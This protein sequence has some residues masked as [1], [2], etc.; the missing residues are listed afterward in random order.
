MASFLILPKSFFEIETKECS[1]H[2]EWGDIPDFKSRYP[3]T[4]IKER[5]LFFSDFRRINEMEPAVDIRIDAVKSINM[6]DWGFEVIGDILSLLAVKKGEK[7]PSLPPRISMKADDLSFSLGRDIGGDIFKVR[8]SEP[9]YAPVRE[10]VGE[11]DKFL[12]GEEDLVDDS[13]RIKNIGQRC[14]GN[15]LLDD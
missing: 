12:F 11:F 10:K 14:M 3:S 15:I 7:A 13:P 4:Y 2:V 5:G 6:Y 9:G 8:W 1:K